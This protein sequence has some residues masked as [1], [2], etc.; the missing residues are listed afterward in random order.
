MLWRSYL[1]YLWLFV[2]VDAIFLTTIVL[3]SDIYDSNV[4]KFD[5]IETFLS[6]KIIG[7]REFSD[8]SR[9]CQII[10]V[11][12]Y[13][14]N[15]IIT[16]CVQELVVV[17]PWWNVSKMLCFVFVVKDFEWHQV[18]SLLLYTIMLYTI[19]VNKY[20][21]L[22]SIDKRKYTKYMSSALR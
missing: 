5:K 14:K 9:V 6:R 21:I 17:C 4:T 16:T 12:S 15:T 19:M 11:I 18:V 10:F 3:R 1:L 7:V 22:I 13:F 2:V 20:T 8:C